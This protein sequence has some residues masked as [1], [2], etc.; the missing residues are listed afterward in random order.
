MFIF[1]RLLNFAP[2]LAIVPQLRSDISGCCLKPHQHSLD[3][4]DPGR[5]STHVL[6][7]NIAAGEPIGN[8]GLQSSDCF[9]LSAA[10]LGTKFEPL[11]LLDCTICGKPVQSHNNEVHTNFEV[12]LGLHTSSSLGVNF[13]VR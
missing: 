5:R 3:G 6:W 2:A 7:R 11:L 9:P 13:W 1:S 10:E 8:E 4:L 12:G